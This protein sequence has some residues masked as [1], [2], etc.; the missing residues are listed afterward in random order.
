MTAI[1][2]KSVRQLCQEVIALAGYLKNNPSD[3]KAIELLCQT[4]EQIK[5][6]PLNQSST[7]NS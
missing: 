6:H 4:A 5:H 7:I 2:Q 3:S 1:A